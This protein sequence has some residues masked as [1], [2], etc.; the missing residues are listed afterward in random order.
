MSWIMMRS[1]SAAIGTALVA[2]AST[3]SAP[4]HA[5][6]ELLADIPVLIDQEGIRLGA[7]VVVETWDEP[8]LQNR[9]D[10]SR[11]LVAGLSLGIPLHQ[12]VV[13]EVE[14]GFHRFVEGV[15]EEGI[16]TGDTLD[17]MPM[18]WQ[19]QG[20]LPVGEPGE[21][22]LGLGP[23]LTPFR[24]AHPD[25]LNA[26][27]EDYAT[28]GVKLAGELRVGFRIDTGLIQPARAPGMGRQFRAVD[29]EGYVA[30]RF[31][32]QPGGQGYDL[33]AFRLGLGLSF[34]F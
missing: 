10:A 14:I 2:M 28:N 29:F 17:I 8:E 20:R 21:V 1:E 19:F 26:E 34:R 9:F 22:F 27:N 15:D 11:G 16:A 4:A 13:T 6:P 18:S 23:T 5:L 30:R 3:W 33:A 31:Q 32:L 7:R 25:H 24:H 12:L